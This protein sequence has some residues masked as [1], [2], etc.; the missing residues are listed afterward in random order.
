MTIA[1]W[2]FIID[3]QG[4]IAYKNTSVNPVEDAKDVLEVLEK[5]G[6]PEKKS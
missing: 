1:R 3:R 5:L 4:K 6:K 2:T